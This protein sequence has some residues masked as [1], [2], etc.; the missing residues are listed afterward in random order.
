MFARIT[1]VTLAPGTTKADLLHLHDR[2]LAM[3]K[4]LP[5]FVRYHAMIDRKGARAVAITYWQTEA[6]LNQ[7]SSELEQLRAAI[8]T[9]MGVL[10]HSA[11]EY[12]VAHYI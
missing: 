4:V 9:E 5:G 3:L 11:A 10:D 2:L 8:F 12:E 1:T 6:D 7:R